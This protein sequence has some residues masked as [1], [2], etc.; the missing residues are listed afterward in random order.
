MV[1]YKILEKC[2]R[3]SAKDEKQYLPVLANTV[4]AIKDQIPGIN[5]VGFFLK[6]ADGIFLGPF[7]GKPISVTRI[8]EGKGLCSVAMK[9]NDMLYVADIHGYPDYIPGDPST[10]CELIFPL[11][12]ANMVIGALVICS[13][14]LNRFSV[15]DRDSLRRLV[16][17]VEKSADF[18]SITGK[19]PVSTIKQPAK[20]HNM[21]FELW[22][23]AVK[24]LAQTYEMVEPIYSQ[25][26]D[27]EKK[28]LQEE[29][30]KTAK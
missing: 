12:A 28:T 14:I 21:P 11:H 6:D 16:S 30:E 27:Q 2:I 22:L 18:S 23:Y 8:P 26:S 24:G 1:D 13:P 20:E 4:S 5:W 7:Q 9:K 10:D 17:L 29:Y 19:M 3:E 15:S 25:L